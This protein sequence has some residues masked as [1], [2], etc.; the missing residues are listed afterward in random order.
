M[1]LRIE[2]YPDLETNWSEKFTVF[3]SGKFYKPRLDRLIITD[4]IQKHISGSRI[5]NIGPFE[6]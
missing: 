4:A 2:N 5:K 1:P 6:D 3:Y